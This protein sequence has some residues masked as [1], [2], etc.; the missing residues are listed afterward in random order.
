M[1]GAYLADS[2]DDRGVTWLKGLARVISVVCRDYSME[3]VA[4]PMSHMNTQK[5][6]TAIQ[7][8]ALRSEYKAVEF[9]PVEVITV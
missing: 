2:R 9:D 8:Q 1:V 6:A 4:I 3:S 7:C 5:T